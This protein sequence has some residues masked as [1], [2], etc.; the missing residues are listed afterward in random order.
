MGL[1]TDAAALL[2]VRLDGTAAEPEEAVRALA[3]HG[4][5]D[6]AHTDD[7]A[8]V[9]A[10]MQARR[11]ALPAL[12]ALGDVMLDDVAVP[13]PALPR[14]L[15]GIEAV[16]RREAVTI[17]T[18]G[19]AAD[20]NLHPTIVLD[21]DDPQSPERARRAFDALVELALELGGTVSGEHG[22]GALKTA[23]LSRQLGPAELALMRRVKQ[24]FDPSGILNPGRAY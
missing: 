13:V 2:V 16:A 8:E 10:F 3:S 14:L 20:A 18:F 9:E 19:H 21:R 11:L 5:R 7:P 23:H 12:E 4:G 1:D 17:G 22:V 24:A 6:L 15:A